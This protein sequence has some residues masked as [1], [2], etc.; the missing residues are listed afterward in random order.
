MKPN[1]LTLVHSQDLAYLRT[2]LSEL[3]FG[4]LVIKLFESRFQIIGVV[5][6]LLCAGIAATA[7]WRTQ[8]S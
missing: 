5:Y 3:S 7:I 8:V 1:T 2:A 6:V 4:V